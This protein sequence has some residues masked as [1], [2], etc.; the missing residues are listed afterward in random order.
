[1]DGDG[2]SDL[3][4]WRP[5]SGIWYGALSTKGYDTGAANRFAKLWGTAGDI[6]LVGDMDGDG[7]SDLFIW[8]PS[9]GTWY[10]GLS[11][12]GYDTTAA[13]RFTKAWGTLGDM[14]LD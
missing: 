3:F 5:S 7:W 13:Q 1:M 10:G 14:P 9:T 8:R 11:S 12:R 4:I 6:P 2:W